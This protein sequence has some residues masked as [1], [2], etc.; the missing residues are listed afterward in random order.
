LSTSH[1]GSVGG[2]G[3]RVLGDR[4]CVVFGEVEKILHV[5]LEVF[6][7]EIGLFSEHMLVERLDHM[8]GRTAVSR[9]AHTSKLIISTKGRYL[10]VAEVDILAHALLPHL[11]RLW[12]Y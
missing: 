7:G 10:E 4:H 2:D 1:S 9:A 6:V 11:A 12:R 8:G 5:A 3:G